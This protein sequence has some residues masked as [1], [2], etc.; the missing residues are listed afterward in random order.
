MLIVSPPPPLSLNHCVQQVQ[1]ISHPSISD[2]FD[3]WEVF[4]NDKQICRFMESVEEYASN[5]VDWREEGSTEESQYNPIPMERVLL[6]TKFDRNYWCKLKEEITSNSEYEEVNV[7]SREDPRP[8]K[9]GNVLDSQERKEF[10]DL[11]REFRDLFAWSY[12][13]KNYD[14]N[15]IQHAI[16]LEEN[17]K[18]HLQKL[19]KV[20]PKLAPLVKK[21]LRRWW[22]KMS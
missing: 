12:N 20:N 15:I 21:E 13:N 9:V 4:N 18:P 3:N 7:G 11:V 5:Q 8:I 16:P 17:V 14:K 2:N 10:I 1:V 6:E 22:K 19:R